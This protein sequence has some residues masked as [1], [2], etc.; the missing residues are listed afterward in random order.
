MLGQIPLAPEREAGVTPAP[1]IDRVTTLPTTSAGVTRALFAL[2]VPFW[3]LMVLIAVEDH[4]GDPGIRWW[5]P[6]LWESSSCLVATGFLLVQRWATAR[7]PVPLSQPWRWFLRQF[8]WLPVATLVFVP[9][10][11]SIRIGVYTLAGE[12]YGHEP[13]GYLFFYE[14]IK[15]VLFLGLWLGIIFGLE[16]FASWRAERERLLQ[17]Q[18]HL[19]ESQLAQLKSQLQPHFLFNALNTISSL[20]HV[21][22]DRADRLL[23]QLADLLRATLA[24]GA[25]DVGPLRAEIEILKL[26]A[27]VMEERFAGRVTLEWRIADETLDAAVPTL[28]LQPVLENA[29]KHGVEPSATPVRIGVEARRDGERL[30]LEVRNDGTLGGT[31]GGHGIGLRNSRE[32]LAVMYGDAAGLTLAEQTGQVV[33]RLTLPW[34]RAA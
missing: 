16:S 23:A 4:R 30:V 22:V 1:T 25:R 34:Q 13:W 33:A 12:T 6:V 9:L 26:Y 27:R 7:W 14:G 28:L 8:A 17:L 2:W 32:R 24:S 5:M 10:V 18:K 20:M 19:A 31:G 21:D 29:F 3:L 11:F 15:L